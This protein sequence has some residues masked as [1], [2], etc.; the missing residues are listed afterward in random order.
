MISDRI[1]VA[2]LLTIAAVTLA[3]VVLQIAG[4]I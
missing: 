1:L 4:V 2:V 3:S